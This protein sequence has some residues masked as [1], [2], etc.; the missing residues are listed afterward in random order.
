MEKN[1]PNP[2][3][4]I[5]FGCSDK[6]KIIK[7]YAD[8]ADPNRVE[9]EI[10]SYFDAVQNDNKYVVNS[11][12]EVPDHNMVTI[13]VELDDAEEPL[14]QNNLLPG[15]KLVGPVA[16]HENKK[17]AWVRVLDDN[18]INLLSQL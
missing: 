11:Y 10:E 4:R 7:Y 18:I 3:I 13:Y 2:V 6:V 5:E 17:Y 8:F 1:I 14:L 16:F 12:G 15:K 9:N